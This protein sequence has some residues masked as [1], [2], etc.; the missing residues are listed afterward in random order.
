M[1]F[2]FSALRCCALSR[3]AEEAPS[4]MELLLQPQAGPV[5]AESWFV[6]SPRAGPHRHR[7]THTMTQWRLCGLDQGPPA[8]VGVGVGVGGGGK[9]PQNVTDVFVLISALL[10]LS[11]CLS[12]HRQLIP[13]SLLTSARPSL[14]PTPIKQ[15]CLSLS[16][17]F[18][19]PVHRNAQ[20]DPFSTEEQTETLVNICGRCINRV[21]VVAKPDVWGAS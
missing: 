10:L 7:A 2:L 20:E 15:A 8:M 11:F 5:S 9:A 4:T 19:L 6:K 3:L 14:S 1:H 18:V 17:G 12:V 21:C 16:S 13:L